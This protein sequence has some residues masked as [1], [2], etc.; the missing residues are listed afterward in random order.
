MDFAYNR[1][2]SEERKILFAKEEFLQNKKSLNYI[3]VDE[4]T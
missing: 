4:H 3:R 1:G 2:V